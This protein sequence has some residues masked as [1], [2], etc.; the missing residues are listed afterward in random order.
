MVKAILFD[1]GQTL[2]DSSEG[3]RAAEK[4]AQDRLYH[5]LAITDR[6]VF[7]QEYRRIRRECHGRSQLSRIA[8]WTEVYWYYCRE[9]EPEKLQQWERDYWHTVE[10]RTQAFPEALSVLHDLSR[11]Y[12]LALITNTQAQQ[13]GQAHRIRVYPEFI[14]CFKVVIVAGEGNVPPKPDPRGFELCLEQLRRAPQEA[15]YVGDDWQ[16]DICGAR[17]LG[18]R[19][20]WLKHRSVKRNYPD[21]TSDVPVI[22]SLSEL[23]VLV[24]SGPFAGQAE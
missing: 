21:V 16:N 12:G 2:V 1:W 9:A 14:K 20:I 4:Q 3:F 19:P 6:D 18:I 8:I 13:D 17:N 23:P 11:Q 5:D 15:V 22:T 7:M 10:D 24:S